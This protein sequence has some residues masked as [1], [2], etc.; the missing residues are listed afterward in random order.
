MV[1]SNATEDQCGVCG[2]NGETC[3]I[4]IHEFN[5][6]IN[7]SEG[8]YKIGT[9]KMGARNVIIEEMGP[10]KNYIAI[11]NADTT[12]FYLNGER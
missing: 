8:Y 11:A 7:I 6:K 1:D 2:G 3:K 12:E 10:S 9:V 5:K 4:V